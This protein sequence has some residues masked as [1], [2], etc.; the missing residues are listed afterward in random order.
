MKCSPSCAQVSPKHPDGALTRRAFVHSC[1]HGYHGSW[2][3]IIHP[4]STLGLD[5]TTGKIRENDNTW[6]D[7]Q[8]LLPGRI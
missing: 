1:V 6:L 3:D 2:L 7:D 4:F 5:Q 8:P